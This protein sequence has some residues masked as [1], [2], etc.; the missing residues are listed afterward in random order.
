M[1]RNERLKDTWALQETQKGDIHMTLDWRPITLEDT[2]E[3]REA[4]DQREVQQAQKE[5]E[6]EENRLALLEDRPESPLAMQDNP[7]AVLIVVQ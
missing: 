2:G 4:G 3:L 5:Q 1:V 6:E 7:Q